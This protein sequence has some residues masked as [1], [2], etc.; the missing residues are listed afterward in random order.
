LTTI[1]DKLRS[2]L[3]Q[4]RKECV[5]CIEQ[6]TATLNKQGDMLLSMMKHLSR[7]NDT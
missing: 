2:E 6:L 1:I 7:R 4:T 5:I 3:R